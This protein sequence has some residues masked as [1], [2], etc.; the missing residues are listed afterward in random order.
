MHV[1]KYKKIYKNIQ[2]HKCDLNFRYG[3]SLNNIYNLAFFPIMR[4]YD[5]CVYEYL[6]A[7]NYKCNY[8]KILDNDVFIEWNHAS[9]L[10]KFLAWKYSHGKS[11]TPWV[12][13]NSFYESACL[14]L[15]RILDNSQ[16][17]YEIQLYF[18]ILYRSQK[19]KDKFV[20]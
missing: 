17:N 13:I 16:Q 10:L 5:G 7:F 15:G 14:S 8:C 20:N 1:Q 12:R 11:E 4:N 6:L 3:K 18:G 19:S 2:W 9:N